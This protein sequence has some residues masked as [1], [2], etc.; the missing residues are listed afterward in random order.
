MVE[1]ETL[2]LAADDASSVGN[3]AELLGAGELGTELGT[4]WE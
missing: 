4:A 2:P 3:V 1:V